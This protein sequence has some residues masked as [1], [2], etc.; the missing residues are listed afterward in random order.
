[1]TASV[2]FLSIIILIAV[3]MASLSAVILLV[4]WI[5][6]RKRRELW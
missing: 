4:L 3:G 5:K 2:S 1:M 6:D